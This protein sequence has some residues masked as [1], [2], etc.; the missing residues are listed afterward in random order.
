DSISYLTIRDTISTPPANTAK[1]R[2][3]NLVSDAPAYNL[4]ISNDTTAFSNRAYKTYT[5]F[6][7]VKPQIV[8]LTLRDKNT[9]AV[10]ASLENIEFKDQKFYTVWAKG[11]VNTT[12]AEQKLSIQVSQHF[13]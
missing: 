5:S 10:V 9:N 11:L 2:F 7:N 6:K 12:V 8:K 3:I 4:E 1:V 13:Q